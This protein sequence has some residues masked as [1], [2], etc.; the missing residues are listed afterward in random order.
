MALSRQSGR[1]QHHRSVVWIPPTLNLSLATRRPK[2]RKWTKSPQELRTIHL[3]AAI[4]LPLTLSRKLAGDELKSVKSQRANVGYFFVSANQKIRFQQNKASF[5]SMSGKNSSR[6][7]ANNVIMSGL[8]TSLK[9]G[10]P[11]EVWLRPEPGISS[12]SLI[13]SARTWPLLAK[14]ATISASLQKDPRW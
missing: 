7:T 3:K 4:L 11:A 2:W 14:S 8:L 5:S 13:S 1:F 9:E 10:H 6:A 12:T